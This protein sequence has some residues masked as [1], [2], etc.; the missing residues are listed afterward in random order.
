ML[1]GGLKFQNSSY[2]II[3]DISGMFLS[4]WLSYMGLSSRRLR[5]QVRGI[6]TS[7][8]LKVVLGE[9]MQVLPLAESTSWSRV[10]GLSTCVKL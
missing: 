9:F 6:L 3:I 2:M 4:S 5:L 8:R 7:V 1:L 10:L